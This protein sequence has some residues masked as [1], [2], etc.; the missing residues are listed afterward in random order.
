MKKCIITTLAM[1]V[2]IYLVSTACIPPIEDLF[3]SEIRVEVLPGNTEIVSGETTIDYGFVI[4]GMSDVTRDFVIHNDGQG[5]LILSGNPLVDLSGDETIYFID[6][7]PDV[8]INPGEST[9]FRVRMTSDGSQQTYNGTIT[10][11]NSDVDESDFNF[12]VTGYTDSS[13]P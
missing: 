5:I 4:D 13:L 3:N 7:T 6:V 2:M 10:I 11:P 12:D 9:F 8:L 1:V